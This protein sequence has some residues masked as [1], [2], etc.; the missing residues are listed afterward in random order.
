MSDVDSKPTQAERRLAGYGR[1]ALARAKTSGRIDRLVEGAV[2]SAT[3]VA[4]AQVSQAAQAPRPG[5]GVGWP[6]AVGAAALLGIVTLAWFT[7]R[8]VATE[9]ATQPAPAL[10]AVAPRVTPAHVAPPAS[11]PA[12]T[13]PSVAVTSLPDAV[14]TKPTASAPATAPTTT[15]PSPARAQDVPA[16]APKIQ[17]D[18]AQ[19]FERANTARRGGDHAA[20]ETLYRRLVDAYPASREAMTSRVIL[21][22]MQLAQGAA[23]EALASFDAYLAGAPHGALEEQALIG[24]AQSL[25]SLGRRSEERAAWRALLEAFPSTASRRTALE[26][27]ATPP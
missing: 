21:G 18:A 10:T 7:S 13:S 8:E 14:E 5:F 3:T 12:A 2:A 6:G 23:V 4:A 15:A 25:E 17:E 1:D 20:A 16:A 11:E 26:R 9:Q 19:L 22:R 27:A 24:R